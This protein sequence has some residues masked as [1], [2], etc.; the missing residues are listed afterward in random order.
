MS[1]GVGKVEFAKDN[2]YISQIVTTSKGQKVIIPQM[3]GSETH[4]KALN[5]GTYEVKTQGVRL[6]KP[7]PKVTILT[8][9]E[10]IA[11]YGNNAG[12]NLQVL[13]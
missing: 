10:L 5:D 4:V 9:D 12:K 2:P 1:K 7:E 11:K 6:P 3:I 8:E 13:A